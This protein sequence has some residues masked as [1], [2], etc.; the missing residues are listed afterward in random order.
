MAIDI[1]CLLFV[2]GGFYMGYSKGIIKTVFSVI[3]LLFGALAAFKFAP[4]MTQFLETSFNSTNPL[5]FLAG[6]ALSFVLAM[7]LIRLVARG[8]EGAFKTA[9]I[10]VLNQLAGGVLFAALMTVLFSVLLWFGEQAHLVNQEARLTSKTY[11]ILKEVPGK[12]RVAFE[13]VRPVF[14]D[15]WD[16]SL[17]MMDRLEEMSIEQTENNNVYDIPTDEETQ[18]SDN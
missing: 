8:L 15:F 12:A 13:R 2:V 4:A 5:M 10:N 11:P 9:N 14:R 18:D 3:G 16:Q 6:F 1:M 17:D 7:F